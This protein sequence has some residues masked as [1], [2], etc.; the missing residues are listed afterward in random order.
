MVKKFG[1]KIRVGKSLSNGFRMAKCEHL[2]IV[3]IPG[4]AISESQAMQKHWNNGIASIGGD[5]YTI[6]LPQKW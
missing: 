1:A 6:E 5:F 2:I 3:L 4:Q